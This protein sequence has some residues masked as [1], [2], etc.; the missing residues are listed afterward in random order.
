MWETPTPSQKEKKNIQRFALE[1]S[2]KFSGNSPFGLGSF[3]AAFCPIAV[4]QQLTNPQMLM[5]HCQVKLQRFNIKKSEKNFKK[6]F[7]HQ[8]VNNKMCICCHF[9]YW[10]KKFEHLTITL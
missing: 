6:N 3:L 9:I 8:F 5:K 2:A 4:W 7:K 10:S 1:T